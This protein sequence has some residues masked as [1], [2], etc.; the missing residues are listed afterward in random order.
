MIPSSVTS[1]K[2]MMRMREL[3]N[4]IPGDL[5]ERLHKINKELKALNLEELRDKLKAL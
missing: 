3:L 1:T 2:D 4:K 5:D